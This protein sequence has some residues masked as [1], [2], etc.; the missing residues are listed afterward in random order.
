MKNVGPTYQ[1]MEVDVNDMLVKNITFKQLLQELQE[2]F[3]ILY[4]H[5]TKLNP[6]KY[7]FAIK[8]RGEILS[9]LVNNR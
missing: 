3:F 8:K 4:I 7:A 2:V 1:C 9:F 6:V 5:Q